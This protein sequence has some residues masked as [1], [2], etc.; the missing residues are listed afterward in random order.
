MWRNVRHFKQAQTGVLLPS[1]SSDG[2]APCRHARVGD[3]VSLEYTSWTLDRGVRGPVVDTSTGP[4]GERGFDP[5]TFKLGSGQAMEGLDQSVRGMCVQ[6]TR[7]VVVPPVMAYGHHPLLFSVEMIALKQ[8]RRAGD[9][10][11]DAVDQGQRRH[12]RGEEGQVQEG[13]DSDGNSNSNDNDNDS[14]SSA[15]QRGGQ[16]F[17]KEAPPRLCAMLNRSPC[18][19]RQNTCGPCLARHQGQMGY[20]NTKCH[21]VLSQ[22]H[23][24]DGRDDADAR[25]EDPPAGANDVDNGSINT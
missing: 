18:Y 6:E 5:Y 23:A 15:Q 7:L 24:V 21:A 4:N 17:C 11:E 14:G 22:S 16:L 8:K 3:T 13:R 9:N 25:A 19:M 12:S 20:A 1:G 2:M 10:G